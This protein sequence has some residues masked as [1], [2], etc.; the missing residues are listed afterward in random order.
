MRAQEL[1]SYDGPAGLQLV[2]RPEPEPQADEA[3]VEVHA[4]GVNFPDLL[5]TKGQYQH[6]PD[7]PFVPGCEIA[8]VIR[9]APVGSGW[10]AG[11]RIGAFLW[12][13]GYAEVARV[14]LRAMMPVSDGTELATAAAMV[15][16]YHT[17]LFA[18]ER[19]G[20]VREG[21]TVLVLG[22]AGGIGT[23]GMQVAK[24]LGARVIG[25]VAD[26]G[27]ADVASA[28]GA[29]DVVVL[30]EG[31]SK[32]I[33]ELTGGRGVDAVLDP[34][35]D[36]I[37]DEALRALAPEGRILIIGF[38]AGQI[39]KLGVN[40]LL[41][42][43]ASAVGVAWGAFLDL[44]PNLMRTAGERLNQM[45]AAGHVRPQIGARFAFEE[46]PRALETLGRGEIPGKGVVVVA[47][48]DGH[49]A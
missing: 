47:A 17:T 9:R 29:D 14:P 23:A 42:R 43:N 24:G 49:Q 10:E 19:R 40:R 33:R 48:G 44:D 1:H 46:I 4:I 41:L 20:Q 35:G 27:Q 13:G 30:E 11:Q 31:F 34:L 5:A 2:D 8:G 15:V 45:L 38:A 16:N 25:G 7:L 37:F 6:K 18:L 12:Q 21:E 32:R 26:E 36:W 28:A 39:P 3:L 22:A